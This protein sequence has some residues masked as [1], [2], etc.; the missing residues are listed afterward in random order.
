MDQIFT[1]I[2]TAILFGTVGSMEVLLR[3][4]R[5]KVIGD[6]MN[7]G[8]TPLMAAVMTNCAKKVKLLLEAGADKDAMTND[9]RTAYWFAYRRRFIDIMLLLDP[10]ATLTADLVLPPLSLEEELFTECSPNL[11]N[12]MF[13]FTLLKAGA[14]IFY[15]PLHNSTECESLIMLAAK[16]GHLGIIKL[17]IN[18][19]PNGTMINQC[20]RRL[21]W[22]ALNFACSSGHFE[23]VNLLLEAGSDPNWKG[24]SGETLLMK[25]AEATHF[26]SEEHYLASVWKVILGRVNINLRDIFSCT[27]LISAC[28]SGN[29]QVAEILLRAGADL[30]VKTV[31]G[32]TALI[33]A[34]ENGHTELAE[35]LINAG[36]DIQ[37]VTTDGYTALIWACRNKKF[38][39]AEILIKKG[40][41]IHVMNP[42]ESMIHMWPEQDKYTTLIKNLYEYKSKL[43]YSIGAL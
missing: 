39:L 4:S 2:F 12:Q 40:A 13:F 5:S 16:N 23:I 38:K 29:R 35:M 19:N 9:G 8:T 42:D 18:I 14:N 32:S 26:D 3:H 30:N 1:G 34:C 24:Y 25:F 41:D 11:G 36:A 17:I 28:K 43:P 22:N 15:K 6:K 10:D 33:V 20:S 31:Y 37:A 27:A 7:D 21:K